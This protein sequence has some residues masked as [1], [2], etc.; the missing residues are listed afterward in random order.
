MTL[1]IRCLPYELRGHLHYKTYF[2]GNNVIWLFLSSYQ[3]ASDVYVRLYST[4][5]YTLLT[6]S[7][8]QFESPSGQWKTN[9]ELVP[10][11]S[12]NANPTSYTCKAWLTS[13]FMR[14][15]MSIVVHLSDIAAPL[16]RYQSDVGATSQRHW[17]AIEATSQRHRSDV[18]AT[19]QR[20]WSDVTVPSKRR[21]SAIGVTIQCH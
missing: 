10:G 6:K 21:R 2:S 19:S 18:A 3:Q 1:S 5:E 8:L 12:M 15:G 17:S 14:V 4:Y 13:I 20:H 11:S 16:E 7:S 9:L